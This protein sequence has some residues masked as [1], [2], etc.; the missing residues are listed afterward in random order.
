MSIG[1]ASVFN[2]R[3]SANGDVIFGSGVSIADVAVIGS[4]LEILTPVIAHST[5]SV[6]ACIASSF[7]VDSAAIFALSVEIDGAV[8]ISDML[9]ASSALVDGALSASGVLQ[10]GSSL[11]VAG[12]ALIGSSLSTYMGIIVGND[13][14]VKS[15]IRLGSVASIF[16]GPSPVITASET[17]GRL[18]GLWESD[19]A[20]TTSDRRLKKN[21]QPLEG[22]MNLSEIVD[23]LRPVSFEMI[24]DDT[25]SQRYGFIAQ[26]LEQVLPSLVISTNVSDKDSGTKAVIYQDMI[27]ILT[28]MIQ[29]QDARISELTERVD[30]ASEEL[31]RA[32]SRLDEN[33]KL[34]QT[35][36][37]RRPTVIPHLI[38]I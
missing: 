6:S 23:L 11:S 24:D 1:G 17:G 12:K 13:L 37:S 15:S 35:F 19:F 14:S 3:C 31:R 22:E 34:I 26:E 29:K 38:Q 4:E 36:E 25:H 5:L 9:E 32:K 7:S 27:A 18:H 2:A 28:L 20:I 16:A 8:D 30:E 10:A 21:I 33:E